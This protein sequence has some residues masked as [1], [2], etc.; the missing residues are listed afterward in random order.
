MHTTPSPSLCFEFRRIPPAQLAYFSLVSDNSITNSME[1]CAEKDH[2]GNSV[3]TQHISI[4]LDKKTL[5]PVDP[6]D[7]METSINEISRFCKH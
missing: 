6:V 7:R 2:W 5:V 4:P 3:C 1:L